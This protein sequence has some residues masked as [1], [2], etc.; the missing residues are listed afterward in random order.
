MFPTLCRTASGSILAAFRRG[1]TKDSADGNVTVAESLDEGRTW[2]VVCDGFCSEFDGLPG[3]IRLAALAELKPGELTAYLN[4]F[5]RPTPDSRLYDEKSDSILPSRLL[6]AD[7]T[8]GGRTWGNY[9]TLDTGEHT[10][11]ALTGILS[12]LPDGSV[13]LHFE[14]YGPRGGSGPVVHAAC[15][16]LTSDGRSFSPVIIVAED[17][18]HRRY[19]WDQRLAFSPHH[20]RPVGLFWTYDRASERDLPIHIS[21]GSPD[22]RTWEPPRSTGIRGQIAAPLPLPDGR[23]LAF[24]VHRHPPGSMRLVASTDAGRT[25]LFEEELE[26]YRSPGAGEPGA[27]D[28][29][30]YARLWE[31]MQKTWTFGHPA[32][33]LLSDGTLL[34]AYYAGESA[35]R[36]GARWARVRV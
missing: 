33:L 1:S 23:L 25:W 12:D 21:W 26:V 8:D 36:L 34:L 18:S 5:H 6:L 20:G 31:D 28:E 2:R 22:A 9:R 13:M 24:Y 3:E 15:G 19:H 32:G 11:C 17:A 30:D 27:A 14:S 4:W 29:S 7:S 35:D 10:G 16:R